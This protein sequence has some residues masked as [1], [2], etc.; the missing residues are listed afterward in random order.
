[1]NVEIKIK[2]TMVVKEVYKIRGTAPE[3]QNLLNDQVQV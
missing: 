2:N 3:N 1:M